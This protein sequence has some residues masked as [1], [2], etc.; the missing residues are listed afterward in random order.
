MF[1]ADMEVK[2]HDSGYPGI[3]NTYETMTPLLGEGS[4]V[5]SEIQTFLLVGP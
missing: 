2:V 5:Y 4:D 3:P 1:S